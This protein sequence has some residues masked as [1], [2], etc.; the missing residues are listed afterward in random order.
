MTVCPLEKRGTIAEAIGW[1]WEGALEWRMGCE[2]S[3]DTH[4][5][6]RPLQANQARTA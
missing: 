5:R 3:G 4:T 6:R 2:P 1:S